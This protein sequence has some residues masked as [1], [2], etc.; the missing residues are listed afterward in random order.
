MRTLG[1]RMSCAPEESLAAVDK[2]FAERDANFKALRGALQQLA[3]ARAELLAAATVGEGGVRVVGEVLRDV[4]P[5][6]FCRWPPNWL[7]K[8][9]PS[10]CWRWKLPGNSSSRSIRRLGRTLQRC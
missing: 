8:S 6:L 7:R 3:E 1:D 9:I 2:L 5:E 10:R 4:H